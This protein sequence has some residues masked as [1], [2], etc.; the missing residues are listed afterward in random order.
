MLG[1]KE[2]Q[3]PPSSQGERDEGEQRYPFLSILHSSCLVLSLQ[4]RIKNFFTIQ[5]LKKTFL[6]IFLQSDNPIIV[7]LLNF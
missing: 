3:L 6:F 1:P 4:F 2:I 5:V 7:Y